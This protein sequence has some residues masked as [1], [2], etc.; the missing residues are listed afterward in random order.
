MLCNDSSLKVLGIGNL[1]TYDMKQENLVHLASI[2]LQEIISRCLSNPSV[3]KHN[4]QLDT[5]NTAPGRLAGGQIQSV[6]RNQDTIVR[7][8]SLVGPHSSKKINFRLREDTLF[9]LQSVAIDHRIS[10][11]CIQNVFGFC[12]CTAELFAGWIRGIE[13]GVGGCARDDILGKAEDGRLAPA[14]NGTGLDGSGTVT[15]DFETDVPVGCAWDHV[16]LH[17]CRRQ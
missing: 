17:P 4:T 1:G 15:S 16:Q 2:R 13:K 12:Q 10:T 9:V 3:Y 14:T 7:R 11:G 5:K 8:Y 6:K